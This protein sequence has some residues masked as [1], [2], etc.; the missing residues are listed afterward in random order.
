MAKV[1][2]VFFCQNCGFESPKWL[3]K[4]NSC[5]EWN[6]FVEEKVVQKNSGKTHVLTEEK[7]LPVNINTIKSGDIPR[8]KTNINEFNRV[9]GGGF[10]P[11][12]VILLGG[13]P[14]I[15]KSTLSLQL[16]LELSDRKV[17]YVSGEE[18][19]L[20]IKMRSDR[21]KGKN[22]NCIIYT[23]TDLGKIVS[24]LHQLEPISS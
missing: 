6:T 14:G 13:E 7:T 2:S 23:E 16:C 8:L 20:Q 3:G 4:C 11:G 1:K 10:V 9:L 22:E 21:L 5:N 12:S 18:S 19:A 17:V 24:Q 15:G